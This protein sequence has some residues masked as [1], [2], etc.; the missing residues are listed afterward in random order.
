VLGAPATAGGAPRI[1]KMLVDPR[2]DRE[3]TRFRLEGRTVRATV[4]GFSS[5]TTPRCCPD[6]SRAYA[7]E[8]R[9]GRYVALPGPAAGSV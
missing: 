5:D 8:W 6:L 2:E 7:W 4:L 1:V 3:I 9:H